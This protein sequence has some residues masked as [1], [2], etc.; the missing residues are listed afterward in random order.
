MDKNPKE[1]NIH[2]STPE[3]LKSTVDQSE[4]NF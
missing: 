4:N 2:L 3:T 1:Q